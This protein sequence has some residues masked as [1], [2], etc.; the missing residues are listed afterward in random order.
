MIV[1]RH[2]AYERGLF[3]IV[4]ER[5]DARSTYHRSRTPGHVPMPSWPMLSV[6]LRLMESLT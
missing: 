5:D 3:L 4:S 1:G 2:S 6:V